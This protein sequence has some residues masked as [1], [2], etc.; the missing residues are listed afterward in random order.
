LVTTA[1]NPA[2]TAQNPAIHHLPEDIFDEFDKDFTG[3]WPDGKGDGHLDQ[4]IH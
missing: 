2:K 3:K 4:D 1:C